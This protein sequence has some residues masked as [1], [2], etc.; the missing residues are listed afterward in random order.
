MLFGFGFSI[1]RNNGSPSKPADRR[2]GEQGRGEGEREKEGKEKG[3]LFGRNEGFGYVNYS[4]AR[5][6]STNG[7]SF[8]SAL[9]MLFALFAKAIT[10]R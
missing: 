3:D 5:L 7:A 8:A 6:V 4:T 9:R 1:N 10:V 2:M